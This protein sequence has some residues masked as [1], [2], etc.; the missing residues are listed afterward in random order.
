M[1]TFSA[2]H[3]TEENSA[4]AVFAAAKT[5]TVETRP[6]IAVMDV[7]LNTDHATQAPLLLAKGEPVVLTLATLLAPTTSAAPWLDTVE[8]RRTTALILET[9]C[10]DMDDA[11]LMPPL[12][13]LRLRMC[14]DL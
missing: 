8:I 10:W 5:D 3:K 1:T 7:N 2:D 14:R 4:Q 11:I 6:I 9:V 13:E 12:L